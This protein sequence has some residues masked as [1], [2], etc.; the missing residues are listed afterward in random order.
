[1]TRLFIGVVLCQTFAIS[2]EDLYYKWES[3]VLLSHAIGQ[4]YI[5]NNTPSSIR[6]LLQ[7][8]LGRSTLSQKVKVEPTLRKAKVL[9]HAS[10]LGL[11]SRMKLSGVGLVETTPTLP[12][13][14]AT[15]RSVGKVG[16]ST[17]A[18]KC[19]D[20]EGISR[21]KRNCTRQSTSG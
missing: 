3:I 21:D 13:S 6:S 18:F 9:D 17:I 12:S 10:M 15:P 4:R 8:E 11:G 19:N 1:M 2:P 5:D 20:I 14:F 16:T 7:S